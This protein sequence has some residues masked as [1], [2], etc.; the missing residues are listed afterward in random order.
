VT[1]DGDRASA[2][3]AVVTGASAG[4][5]RAI[6]EELGRHGYRVAL[7]ARGEGGLEAAAAAVRAAGGEAITIP[8]DVA[9]AAAVDAAAGRVEAELGDIGV[10]VN[11]AFASVFARS[12]EITPEEY[13][14]ITQVCYLGFVHGTLAALARMR[15]RDAGTIIQVGSALA[16][17]GIPLQAAYCGAKHAIQGF[18]ES[19]R[20]ELLAER[21]GVRTVMVQLPA[22]NTPQFGWVLSRLPKVPQPVPP[23]YQPEVIARGVLHAI[24]HPR[25]RERWIGGSTALT[26]VA[27]ALVPGILDHYLARTG[28]RS[29][30]TATSV[31]EHP[32][33]KLGNLWEPVDTDHD[34]G[35]HGDFDDRSHGHSLQQLLARLTG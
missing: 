14:R 32:L 11:V 34:F 30:L 25:R 26:L 9:D 3:V 13:A 16:Y 22:V 4:V 20:C 6:A 1:A 18:N 27:N 5:G 7:L 29:Q 12:W 2:P 28:I 19:L 10:W 21:S 24:E 31:D 23:I 33:S 8:V 15:P 17:R 35:S